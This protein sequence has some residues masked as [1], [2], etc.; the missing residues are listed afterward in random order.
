MEMYNDDASLKGQGDMS[1]TENLVGPSRKRTS[2]PYGKGGRYSDYGTDEDMLAR[3][4]QDT[5][6]DDDQ[7]SRTSYI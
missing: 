3:A 1:S 2:T 5:D 7:E 6:E 4:I